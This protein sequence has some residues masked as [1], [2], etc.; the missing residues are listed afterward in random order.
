MEFCQSCPG[1]PLLLVQHL[2]LI[3][4]SLLNL[5]HSTGRQ[6]CV[7]NSYWFIMSLF[8]FLLL[9][10]STQAHK[11]Q[12]E[13]FVEWKMWRQWQE[14]NVSCCSRHH[15]INQLLKYSH[16]TVMV[17]SASWGTYTLP[18]HIPPSNAFNKCYNNNSIV[19]TWC[20]C[21]AK[22]LAVEKCAEATTADAAPKSITDTDTS[23]FPCRRK[24]PST[25][26]MCVY[27]RARQTEEESEREGP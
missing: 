11:Q 5:C 3:I 16:R 8:W 1:F 15:S 24:R 12:S 2:L 27:V 22:Q 17:Y 14:A 6:V 20:V 13:L 23:R 26:Y 7:I 4:D 21:S 9:I 19:P 18:I 10:I 25:S